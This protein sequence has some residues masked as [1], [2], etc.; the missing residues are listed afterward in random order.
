[1]DK[2]SLVRTCFLCIF[3]ASNYFG[4]SQKIEQQ[5]LNLYLAKFDL[6]INWPSELKSKIKSIENKPFQPNG[7]SLYYPSQKIQVIIEVEKTNSPGISFP[8]L[9]NGTRLSHFAGNEEDSIIS[10]HSLGDQELDLLNGEWGTQAFFRPKKEFSDY[11]YCQLI[12][13]YD[14][15]KGQVFVYYLFDDTENPFLQRSFSL[16]QF[17]AD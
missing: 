8:N 6:V 7:I 4:Y 10:L 1:M 12:S 3:I 17:V 14:S 2:N 11:E 9:K 13:F 5:D 15:E 16:I